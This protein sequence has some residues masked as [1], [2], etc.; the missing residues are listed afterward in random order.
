MA[1][2]NAP[3]LVALGDRAAPQHKVHGQEAFEFSE[4]SDGALHTKIVDQNG[5]PI[6][7]SN[8]LQVADTD[9]KAELEQIKQQQQQIL[10]RLDDTF[11]TQLTGS[12][13]ENDSIKT[14]IT[15]NNSVRELLANTVVPA[16]GY[17]IVSTEFHGSRVGFGI[18]WEQTI[19]FRIRFQYEHLNTALSEQITLI[20]RTHSRADGNLDLNLAKASFIIWN[21]SEQDAIIRLF[22]ISDFMGGSQNA[23]SDQQFI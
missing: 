6:S 21:D 16:G 15:K 17:V 13:I 2:I 14:S 1:D 9:V 12:I 3:L 22:I 10:Q 11:N 5:N 19:P 7:S 18:R 8:K 20:S 4:G 23:N